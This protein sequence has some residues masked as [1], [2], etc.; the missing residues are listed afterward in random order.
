VLATLAERVSPRILNAPARLDS[1]AREFEEYFAHQRTQFDL[2]LDLRLS[3]GFRR[4][5]LAHLP[6]I[7]YGE[8]A[9]Y[10]SI[11]AAA[12]SPRAV[13]A[14]GSACATNPLPVVVPCHRVIRTDG[15]P[16]GYAGGLEAKLALLALEAVA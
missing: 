15:T 12:G 16:G 11:A 3:S 14:V 7:R 5:V 4:E 10:A 2:P 9:T 13:R 6:D 1:F 8:T